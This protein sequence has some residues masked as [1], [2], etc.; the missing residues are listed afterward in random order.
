VGLLVFGLLPTLGFNAWAQE[1]SG[2]QVKSRVTPGYPELARKMRIA[3]TVKVQVTVAP[4]GTVKDA[5]LIG[6]HP[7]LANVVLDAVKKWRY[8]ASRQETTEN[9]EFHFDPKE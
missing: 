4:V 9:L 8:E 1:V 2:R 3:G 5:R 7:V 6:G